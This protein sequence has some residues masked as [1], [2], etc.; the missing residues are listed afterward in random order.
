MGWRGTRV[1]EEGR[2]VRSQGTWTGLFG[3][4]DFQRCIGR[5]LWIYEYIL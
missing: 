5:R 4:L 1:W 3:D 2:R